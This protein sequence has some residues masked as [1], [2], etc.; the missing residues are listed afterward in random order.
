MVR[1]IVSRLGRS[2]SPSPVILVSL[3]TLLISLA[4]KCEAQSTTFFVTFTPIII[5]AVILFCFCCCVCCAC[6]C[7]AKQRA[8][9]SS[10]YPQSTE[11]SYSTN[12]PYEG[13]EYPQSHTLQS[14]V[15][16]SARVLY[17][18]QEVRNE[19]NSSSPQANT[20]DEVS[21]EPVALPEATLHQGDAPPGYE[22]AI[23]MTADNVI[24]EPQ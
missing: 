22:E 10:K 4:G 15:P 8:T 24:D 3:L 1:G 6:I 20:H 18:A 11:I 5:V 12:A 19:Q 16:P 23:R 13:A 21:S 7:H 9:N 2:F 17:S 14:Y